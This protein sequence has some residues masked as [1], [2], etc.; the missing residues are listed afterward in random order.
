MNS[1]GRIPFDNSYELLPE[2]FYS[3]QAP[4]PVSAPRLI[5]ANY[6]LAKL[7]NIEPEWLDSEE[8]LQALAGNAMPEGA[9]P[10]AT[11]YAGHQFGGWNPQLGDGR[12]VLLGEVIGRD[13]QRYDIQ[14][15]G[16][17]RTPYSRGGDGRSPLGPVLREYI[18]SEAM[19]AFGVPTTR[20]L[21][22]VA[23]GD[24]VAREEF[25]PGAVL[26]RVASSHIRIGTFQFFA[27]RQD[28]EAVRL[29]ADHVIARHYPHIQ[30]GPHIKQGPN[31]RDAENPYLA[32]YS[33]VVERQAW[34][35]AQ[36]QQL[37]FIHGV[38]NT[39]NMLLSGETIDYGPCAFID[40]FHPATV[41][42]S[43]DTRG[44]YAYQNQPAI[45]QSHLSWLHNALLPLF[46]DDEDVGVELAKTAIG[47]FAPKYQA[48]Y[49]ELMLK[50]LGLATVN[51][52]NT[53]LVTDLLELMTQAGAD[54]TLTFRRL[55]ELADTG[56]QGDSVAAIAD[57]P[58]SFSDWLQR[59][60]ERAALE[61]TTAAQRQQT[62]LATNP[63]FI[64][65]N[66]LIEEAIVAA[67]RSDDFAPF[68]HLVDVLA[69]PF[70]YDHK[71]ERYATPPRPEQV[72]AKTFCGT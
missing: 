60:Y 4:T 55:A 45:A 25:L 43:I 10:I 19:A 58:E 26:T 59:W 5:R 15:K 41:Y 37:G 50:K 71:L 62:M 61:S 22:A 48:A 70:H 24:H 27:A 53:A 42:S 12:A 63:V 9:A 30:H 49:D 31:V 21:A 2:R 66:H 33:A 20:S 28:I 36:W 52:E 68:H 40:N 64:P 39:D 16:A 29:L 65:R 72:V 51:A 46:D 56:W 38:M 67:T 3:R 7:L 14:L 35:I 17:G 11:V 32:L 57:L 54:F 18:V 1:S 13:G 44:R 47:E 8:A 69:S 23:S 6:A 34:L